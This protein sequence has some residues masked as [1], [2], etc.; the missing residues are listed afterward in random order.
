MPCPNNNNDRSSASNLWHSVTHA[1]SIH[2]PALPLNLKRKP[3]GPLRVGHRVRWDK[4][5]EG[6]GGQMIT[7]LHG[8]PCF[9]ALAEPLGVV[10][11]LRVLQIRRKALL[12]EHTSAGTLSAGNQTHQNF[13]EAA[14][15]TAGQDSLVRSN[16]TMVR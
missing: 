8:V 1:P 3:L 7:L 11:R 5:C 10:A 12:L 13:Q 6:E 16:H 2:S 4:V 14:Q 15:A 9:E